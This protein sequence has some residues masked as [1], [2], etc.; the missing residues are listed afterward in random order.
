MNPKPFV[1]WAGGKTYLLPELHEILNKLGED[2]GYCEPMVGGGALYWTIFGKFNRRI[3]ADVNKDLINL[4]I[5][6]RDK[7]EEL[8]SELTKS[9]YSYTHK[10]EE[11]SLTTYRRIRASDPD[12]LVK[13][14][15]RIMFL[16]RTCFNGLMRLNKHGQFNVPPGSYRNP[17]ICNAEL[18]RCDSIALQGTM[19]YRS[20]A[21]QTINYLDGEK[22]LLFVDPPYYDDK[23]KFTDY[24]GQFTLADQTA[25]IDCVL[26][27]KR[28]FIYTNKAHPSI[29]S[30]FDDIDVK[31]KTINLKHS[32]QPR[33]TTGVIEQELIAWR[34]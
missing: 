34:I 3:I 9:E 14:A 18:I 27:S 4:Y 24:S 25:L 12:D 16:L 20:N 15:A 11:Q 31:M 28:P 17:E 29:V 32:V 8:I 10:S 30:Q 21:R 1:K 33:Y 19:I 5:I 7:P 22:Y 6:I 2:I 26:G 23:K 13:R